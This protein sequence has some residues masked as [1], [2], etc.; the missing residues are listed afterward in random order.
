MT[1][2]VTVQ[3]AALWLLGGCSPSAVRMMPTPT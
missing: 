2:R 3:L 1:S